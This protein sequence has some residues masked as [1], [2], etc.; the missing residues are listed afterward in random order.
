MNFGFVFLFPFG[1]IPTSQAGKIWVLVPWVRRAGPSTELIPPWFL[2][3]VHSVLHHTH[4]GSPPLAMATPLQTLES[5]P[6]PPDVHL[7]E[8][9]RMNFRGAFS[10]L[11]F[12]LGQPSPHMTLRC[13]PPGQATL[14]SPGPVYP[15]VT[16]VSPP[17]PSAH[18]AP[19]V[20]QTSLQV[21][22]GSQQV[23]KAS[24]QL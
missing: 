11:T 16:A 15:V 24:P 9:G 17:S 22:S 2:Q 3:C 19:A 13:M 1:P 23:R 8:H 12:S 5:S 18:G 10:C 14:S 21:W 6:P 4:L 7:L 20:H